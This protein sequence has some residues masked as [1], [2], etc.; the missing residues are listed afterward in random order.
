MKVFQ[1]ED[2]M[3]SLTPKSIFIY[4][5]DK[6]AMIWEHDLQQWTTNGWTKDPTPEYLIVVGGTLPPP[7]AAEP[8]KVK[9]TKVKRRNINAPLQQVP[10]RVI[11]RDSLTGDIEKIQVRPLIAPEPTPKIGPI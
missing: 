1:K 6:R 7:P 10:S 9:P 4:K 8:E 11:S 2:D 3:P 5:A